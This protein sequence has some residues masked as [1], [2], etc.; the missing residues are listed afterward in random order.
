MEVSSHALD[1]KRVDDVPFDVVIF[2]NLTQDHLD[3]HGTMER[4]FSAKRR[5]LEL[6]LRARSRGKKPAA[7]INGDDV[8]GKLLI[9]E[10][11]KVEGI[12]VV[13]YGYSAGNDLKVTTHHV[14]MGGCEYQIEWKNRS[15]LVKTPLTGRFNI[16]NTAAAI[17]GAVLAGVSVREA[18]TA[19]AEAPQVPGRLE[20]A[21]SRFK[22]DVVVDYAHT[23]DALEN[24]CQTLKD[25]SQGR[26]ITVFGCGGDRD[27]S[28]RPLM[29]SVAGKLSDICIVTSDN[30]RSEV[31]ESIIREIEAGM[32]GAKYTVSV[33]RQEAIR[34]AIELARPGDIVLIAGKGHE[35]YQ[36]ISG[37][38]HYF[39]DREAAKAV[40]ATLREEDY[41]RRRK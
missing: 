33:D 19:M 1:Q 17:G 13:S 34:V 6:A 20:I 10:F 40:L 29:G 35:D 22:I 21:G 25:F 37:E 15:Y 41:F 7:L 24:V 38:K 28:K 11:S 26:L 12:K 14:S 31:P 39:S 2:T 27:R 9:E 36:E 3:Y 23:P 5:L 4:Y 32:S 30:P 16:M 18:I 8:Y